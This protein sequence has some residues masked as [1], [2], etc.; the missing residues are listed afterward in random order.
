MNRGYRIAF[1]ITGN[2]PAVLLQ[3]GLLSRRTSWHENGFVDALAQE[4]TVVTVD[5][6]GH[7]DS[8][9][10]TDPRA[11]RSEARADD[12]AAVLDVLKIERVHLVGYSMGGWMAAG[13]AA[14]HPQ[15][16]RSVTI[17]GWDPVRGRAIVARTEISIDFDTV[18]AGARARAPQ[19]IAWINP[20]V[21][22][23]LRAC[24]E[25]LSQVEGAEAAL[26]A[27]SSPVLLW[28]GREDPAHD[29]MKALA[30]RLAGA[31]FRAVP[32]DHLGAMTT[33]AAA[34]IQALREFL[35]RSVDDRG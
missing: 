18:L 24:W 28:A 2:G 25:A 23:G 17:G 1:E 7:G 16:L 21:I 33:H 15:R 20:E 35:H 11:Y 14:C 34:S 8:D 19:L 27:C 26:A 29:A 6:L 22:P 3:H 9:K 32:G 30:P 31:T 12:L 4:F 5:S 13:F 10:P